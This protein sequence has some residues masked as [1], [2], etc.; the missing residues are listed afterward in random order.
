[1]L[2]SNFQPKSLFMN[3]FEK[4]HYFFHKIPRELPKRHSEP[5][6]LEAFPAK[7]SQ[8]TMNGQFI[9]ISFRKAYLFTYLFEPRPFRIAIN[10]SL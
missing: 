3:V 2:Q 8:S 1:M 4:S 9:L 10:L 6:G 5:L 7:I